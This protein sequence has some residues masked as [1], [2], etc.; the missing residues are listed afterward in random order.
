MSLLRTIRSNPHNPKELGKVS[1]DAIRIVIES[2][3]CP[4]EQLCKICKDLLEYYKWKKEERKK[5]LDDACRWI[6]HET[7]LI[8]YGP[9]YQSKNLH[10]S[11]DICTLKE[12]IE[13]YQDYKQEKDEN[14]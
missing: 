4:K 7:L 9:D 6:M 13:L 10:F 14:K 8:F 1:L 5:Y 12:I 3:D 2:C 11:K